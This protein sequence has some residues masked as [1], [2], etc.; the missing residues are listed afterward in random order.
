MH[1]LAAAIERRERRQLATA[2]T[3]LR[4]AVWG[5]AQAFERLIAALEGRAPPAVADAAEL[6]AA[7]GGDGD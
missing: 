4:V 3:A 2:A 1:G 7:L 6:M 5:D